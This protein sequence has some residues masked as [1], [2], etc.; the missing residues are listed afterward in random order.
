MTARTATICEQHMNSMELVRFPATGPRPQ[1]GSVKRSLPP[2]STELIG[3]VRNAIVRARQ[4]LVS[5]Q[6]GDGAWCGRQMG[7]VSLLSQLIFMLAYLERDETELAEQ[8]ATTIRIE[9]RPD[10]GWS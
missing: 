8:C 2:F 9:Q 5:Q 4:C 6:R 1:G 7:A 3:P 10:G